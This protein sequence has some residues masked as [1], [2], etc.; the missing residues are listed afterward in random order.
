MLSARPKDNCH[1]QAQGGKKMVS[2]EFYDYY[3]EK[4]FVQLNSEKVN[5]LALK[6]LKSPVLDLGCYF[7][8]KTKW[9]SGQFEIVHGCDISKK[10]LE[11]ARQNNPG[12]K[13]FQCDF[14]KKKAKTPKK[15]NSIFA[16]EIIEHVFDTQAFL[17]NCFNA[18]NKQGILFL[19]TP[20]VI[21]YSNRL[22]LLLG[23]D[24]FI[25]GDA[26][27]IRFFNPKTIAKEVEKAGFKVELLAGYNGRKIS[28]NIP[29]PP[30]LSEGI[31]LVARKE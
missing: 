4:G 24:I 22:R 13:F 9:L 20:N 16:T 5:A 10:A 18:L 11:K 17:E 25:S 30:S 14:G 8:S 7:G 29:M 23:N 12:T 6:W 3:A 15:Y 21:N 28:R 1:W 26:A 2:E 27:H 31:I 19:T